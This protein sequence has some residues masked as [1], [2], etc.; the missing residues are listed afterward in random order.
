VPL[1]FDLRD[2]LLVQAVP[3][4]P[5]LLL[6]GEV[7]VPGSQT[8]LYDRVRVLQYWIDG[9]KLFSGR[10]ED[11]FARAG[12]TTTQLPGVVLET[13]EWRLDDDGVLRPETAGCKELV[14][15]VQDCGPDSGAQVPDLTPATA[16]VGVGE[17]ADFTTGYPF[18]IR[19]EAGD[20][21]VLVAEG[22][23]GRTLRHGLDVPDPR[24]ATVQPE[25]IFSDGESLVVT[26]ASDPT[27]VQLLVQRDDRIVALVPVGEVP[28]ENTDDSRTWLTESGSV[29][30]AVAGEDDSWQLWF[31]QMTK[32]H[33]VFALP[34][35]TV[36]FD[37][38]DDPT[39]ARAC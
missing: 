29:V 25:S 13:W 15:D 33:R 4:D 10:S 28:L 36:C 23:D 16:T 22:Q 5:E 3:E 21:P 17:S 19:V 7:Q 34:G 26:S 35:T 11:S 6:R 2:G 31:W 14:F 8:G 9:G 37:D 1:V 12:M 27:L 24:V 39:T 20:P 30:S 32:D 38:V 18:S